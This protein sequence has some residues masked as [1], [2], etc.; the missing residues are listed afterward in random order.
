MPDL[1]SSLDL[2]TIAAIVAVAVS[3]LT[4]LD[5]RRKNRAD[6]AEAVTRSVSALLDPLNERLEANQAEVERLDQQGKALDRT[7]IKLAAAVKRLE[8]D[9]ETLNKRVAELEAENAELRRGVEALISQLVR[10]GHAPVWRPGKK[11]GE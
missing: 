4:A 5:S 11:G 2:K 1:L 6:A 10:L 8:C 9:N 7:N 3:I